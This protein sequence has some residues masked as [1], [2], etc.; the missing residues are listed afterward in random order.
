MTGA[1]SGPARARWAGLFDT[2][3]PL[4]AA[5]MAGGTSTPAL[6]SAVASAG[7]FGFLAAGYKTPDAVAAELAEL[8]GTA[9]DAIGV[10]LF[11]PGRDDITEAEFRRYA[12]EL[13]AEG[14]PYGLDLAHAPLVVDDDHWRDKLD[15]LLAAPVPVVSFTFGL[16]DPATVRALR[17]AGSRV[18]VTVTTVP[19]ARA[20]HDLGVDGLVAQS[21]EAGAHSGTHDPRRPLS[22]TTAERLTVEVVAATGLP[23]VA[24]GGVDGAGRVRRLL[25]EGA[26]AV[27]VGTLL[28]RT[29]ESG[30]SQVHK[31][32]LADPARTGT[33]LTRAFTGRPAR[34]LRNGF[35]DRHEA[36][37]PFGYP[38]IH[39]LTRGLRV[40]AVRAND[41]DRVH[42]WAG[43]GYRQARTGP[44]AEAVAAL[45]AAL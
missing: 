40:A 8:R 10:N 30:T 31:D 42:L 43:T 7:G 12:R 1:P 33:V 28:L 5:P 23:V 25:A 18:L 13:A 27:M 38:A 29:D 4:V 20:A 17:R 14:A 34:G 15:L 21:T 41:P 35:I 11:V 6:V 2:E 3:L 24:A 36:T 32:A 37:A 39:H 44:A 22:P 16:P 26:S 45:S 9:G 19:E